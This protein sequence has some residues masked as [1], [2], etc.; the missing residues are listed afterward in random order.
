MEKTIDQFCDEGIRAGYQMYWIMWCWYEGLPFDAHDESKSHYNILFVS[1][2]TKKHRE[3][4]ESPEYHVP[5][6][7]EHYPLHFSAWMKRHAPKSF[8]GRKDA[9]M[10]IMSTPV[11]ESVP[12]CLGYPLL[13]SQTNKPGVTDDPQ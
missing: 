3:Y 9:D 4:K 1:W 7:S 12:S 13:E 11:Q 2:I 10:L 8:G 5:I 6:F